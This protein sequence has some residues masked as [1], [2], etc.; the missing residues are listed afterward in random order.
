MRRTPRFHN[1]D[2]VLADADDLLANGYDRAGSWNLGQV[3][4][5]LGK[6]IGNSLDGYPSSLPLPMRIL[7]RW[8]FLGKMLRHQQSER[9]FPTPPYM[10]PRDAMDD[11]AGLQELRSAMKR[12]KE[13]SGDLQPHPAFGRMTPAQWLEF[14][15]WHCEHHLSFLLPKRAAPPSA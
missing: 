3:C 15:L 4:S 6:A 11:R 1:Y 9:R 7:A 12:L 13:H 10:A 8:L 5:H 2:E 14:H